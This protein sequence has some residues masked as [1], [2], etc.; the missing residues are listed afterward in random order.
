MSAIAPSLAG[1]KRTGRHPGPVLA[2]L[3]VSF[4]RRR[5]GR[6][7]GFW[8]LNEAQLPYIYSDFTKALRD[9]RKA[10][11]PDKGGDTETFQHFNGACMT[12]LRAFGRHGIGTYF[13]LP[14]LRPYIPRSRLGPVELAAARCKSRV[15]SRAYYQKNKKRLCQYRLS[16]KTA[17]RTA[18][19]CSS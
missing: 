15:Y 3:G 4:R 8:E 2:S 16:L 5:Y 11:H 6:C 17:K 1:G 19:K 9:W 10:N 7:G 14:R 13:S 18:T 12:L